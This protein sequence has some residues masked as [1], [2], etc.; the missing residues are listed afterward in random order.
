MSA[1]KFFRLPMSTTPIIIAYETFKK[2]KVIQIYGII[3]DTLEVTVRT[4]NLDNYKTPADALIA[5][6]RE[7]HSQEQH[8]VQPFSLPHDGFFAGDKHELMSVFYRVDMYP[9]EDSIKFLDSVEVCL[10]TI[11]GTSD[12]VSDVRS[13]LQDTRLLGGY[14]TMRKF[15]IEGQTPKVAQ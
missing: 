8:A 14:R 15:C 13:T 3:E 4:I 11:F 10:M 1:N 9:L 7:D 12:M 5:L 2:D 6:F